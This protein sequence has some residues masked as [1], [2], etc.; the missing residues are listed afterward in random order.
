[1]KVNK[2][3]CQHSID[4]TPPCILNLSLLVSSGDK[5]L[6]CYFCLLMFGGAAS[7]LIRYRKPYGDSSNIKQTDMKQSFLDNITERLTTQPNSQRKEVL[8]FAYAHF[9]F[10]NF[11]PPHIA[12]ICL[13]PQPTNP[14]QGQ[15]QKSAIANALFAPFETL[16]LK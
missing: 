7:M 16:S 2:I 4:S 10:F 15:S 8:F 12:H 11:M 14:A 9:L 6:L 1:V 13:C 5:K 3:C